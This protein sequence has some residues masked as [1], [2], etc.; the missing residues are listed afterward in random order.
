AP[1][2][3]VPVALLTAYLVI[4]A[5]TT[6]KPPA[7]GTHRLDVGLLVLVSAVT[8]AFFTLG[9]IVVVTPAVFHGFPAPPFFIF[10]AVA[11]I[12]TIGDVQLIRSGG[13]RA[14][15]GAPRLARHLWRMSTAL[16]IAAF[17][18]FIGQAR[19]I[20]KPYR[21]YPLLM[22]PPLVV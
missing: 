19:V 17:S 1:Q 10:G 8:A 9:S 3:N 2:A 18:F 16:L 7:A 11:L 13:V 5:L 21:V 20:P 6:V 15:R 22:I 12:A 4:T 14:I